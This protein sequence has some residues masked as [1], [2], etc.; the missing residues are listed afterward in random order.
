M[1][2]RV[3][4]M[5]SFT[6]DCLF[7]LVLKKAEVVTTFLQHYQK[8]FDENIPTPINNECNNYKTTHVF[9]SDED[10]ATKS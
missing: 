7:M 5:G 9:L 1:Y 6:A 8:K 10:V 2:M 3:P 4:V